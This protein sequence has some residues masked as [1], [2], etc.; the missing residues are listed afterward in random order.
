MLAMSEDAIAATFALVLIWGLVGAAV[1]GWIGE[2]KQEA[3]A[4]ALFGLFFGPIG[5]MIAALLSRTARSEVLW[6]EELKEER[7]RLA[8]ERREKAAFLEAERERA[9]AIEAAA[10]KKRAEREGQERERAGRP[11]TVK[12]P[13]CMHKNVVRADTKTVVCEV[14]QTALSMN[15]AVS[16]DGSKSRGSKI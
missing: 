3:R 5:W 15:Q 12:C 13:I 10:R 14:C 6:H 11:V 7:R 4:G 9:R 8:E 2:R 1:G 16:A